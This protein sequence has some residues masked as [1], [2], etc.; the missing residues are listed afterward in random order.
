MAASHGSTTMRNTP[1]VALTADNVYVRADGSDQDDVGGTSCAAPLWAGFT[2]LMNQQNGG[3]PVGFLNP[4]LYAIGQSADYTNCFHD[5]TTGD[6]CSLW[7]PTNFPAVAGYDLCTGWGTPAGGKLIDVLT[8]PVVCVSDSNLTVVAVQGYPVSRPLEIWTEWTN[9]M[10]WTLAIATNVGWLSAWPTN[11]ISTG[12][13]NVVNLTCDPS[14]LAIGTYQTNITLTAPV[15]SNSPLTIAVQMRVVPVSLGLDPTTISE[16]TVQGFSDIIQ[17]EVQLSLN[18]GPAVSFS[19]TSDVPWISL[20]VFAGTLSNTLVFP[21]SIEA[22]RLDPG[23]HTGYVTFQSTNA[24]LDPVTL[25]VQCDVVSNTFGDYDHCLTINV[26][27]Y[28]RAEVLT[29][30]PLLVRLGPNIEGFDYS[31]FAQDPPSD[32]RFFDAPA[33]TELPYEIDEWNTNSQSTVW[34]RM[35]SLTNGSAL[36]CFWGREGVQRP[37]YTTNGGAWASPSGAVW[38]MKQPNVADST[39]NGNTGTAYGPTVGSGVIGAALHFDGSSAYITFPDSTSLHVGNEFTFSAWI[40]PDDISGRRDLFSTRVTT[41]GN[42]DWQIE[43]GQGRYYQDSVLHGLFL[44]TTY[45][46]WDVED[47]GSRHHNQ[48]MAIC[49]SGQVQ[50]TQSGQVVREWLGKTP[51]R[52]LGYETMDGQSIPKIPG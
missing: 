20:P 48:R 49:H 51:F 15:A 7:S 11:G 33:G 21:F 41:N 42:N 32:L 43:I 16:S 45:Y 19:A 31:G 25:T 14:G 1:D 18:A 39:G 5:I 4:A 3:M 26:A 9:A 52:R 29:N 8:I 44:A 30:F 37:A 13:Y 35:P 17:S 46:N 22:F 28:S 6:N 47:S 27:G 23:L 50:H 12:D 24:G 10:S 38:H 2:A 34:V 36:Y 40:N